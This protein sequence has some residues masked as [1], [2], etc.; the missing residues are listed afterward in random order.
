MIKSK[1]NSFNLKFRTK[2]VFN[3]FDFISQDSARKKW[4]HSESTISKIMF[5]SI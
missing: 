2:F 5:P 1:Q 4:L 3:Y